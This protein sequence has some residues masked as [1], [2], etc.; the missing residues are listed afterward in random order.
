MNQQ[1][2]LVVNWQRLILN[3]KGSGKGLLEL[4]IRLEESDGSED[5]KQLNHTYM[6]VI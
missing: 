5:F 2:L 6:T 4:S 1:R 3:Q